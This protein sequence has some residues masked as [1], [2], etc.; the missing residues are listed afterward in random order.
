[1]AIDV[2]LKALDLRNEFQTGIISD[3]V[4]A[5]VQLLLVEKV[6]E[7]I[8]VLKDMPQCSQCL[9]DKIKEE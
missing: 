3:Y 6:E 1:M 7:L 4:N 9:C 8:D 5:A 2:R